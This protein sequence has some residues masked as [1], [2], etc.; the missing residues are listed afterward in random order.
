MNKHNTTKY[1]TKLSSNLHSYILQFFPVKEV[2]YFSQLN[3][4][5][6]TSLSNDY[7]LEHFANE[8]E[9]FL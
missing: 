6:K 8:Q 7:I 4:T 2:I 3:S 9:L 1:F 5:F